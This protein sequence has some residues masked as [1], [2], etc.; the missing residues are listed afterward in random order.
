MRYVQTQKEQ[1]YT[2]CV[3]GYQITGR[4]LSLRDI[5]IIHRYEETVIGL[6]DLV[7]HLENK[8][9]NTV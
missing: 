5:T 1:P 3:N 4:N 2:L 8:V 6:I 9:L 7:I